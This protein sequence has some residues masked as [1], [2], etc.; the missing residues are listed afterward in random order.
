MYDKSTIS[1]TRFEVY[2]ANNRL[3][4]ILFLLRTDKMSYILL[5]REFTVPY[6]ISCKISRLA[7][8]ILKL[9]VRLTQKRIYFI[10][11]CVSISYVDKRFTSLWSKL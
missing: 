11:T 10:E 4:G 9:V 6:R 2:P 1:I 8:V 3:Q 7:H 5:Q